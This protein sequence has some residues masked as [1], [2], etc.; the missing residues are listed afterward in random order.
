MLTE[1]YSKL[2]LEIYDT[3]NNKGKVVENIISTEINTGVELLKWQQNEVC[4]F[5]KDLKSVSPVSLKKN[6]TVLREF[7]NLVCKEERIEKRSYYLDESSFML[8]IDQ[9]KLLST[10]LSYEQFSNIR[11]QLGFS[12]NGETINYRDKLIFELAWYS[13]TEDE[14]RMLKKTN[15]KFTK[16][17]V[18][19]AILS[20]IT[21]KI[22]K[23]DDTETIEDL[24]QCI[25]TNEITRMAK[26]GR[27]KTTGYKDSE[28]LI[29]PGTSG[30]RTGTDYLGKPS[31]ALKGT[32]INQDITCDGI[33]IFD[34]SLD[35]IRR[36]RL[37]LL[38]APKNEKLF[39]YKSVAE[40]YNLKTTA[41]LKWHKEVAILKYPQN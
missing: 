14:I 10:T 28:Y 19:V 22:V 21:G 27:L 40:L 4:S 26:D 35:A 39:S 31:R 29:R 30:T 16:L 23:I 13:L 32:F 15:V 24:R 6:L 11:T 1:K 18:D 5:L 3:L 25:V 36:S 33:N 38:L 34:L 20:C 7:A 2:Y 41:G 8:L 12:A 17:H 37:V 9:E